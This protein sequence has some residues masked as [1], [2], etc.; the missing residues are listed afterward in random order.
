MRSRIAAPRPAAAKRAKKIRG[1]N[2]KVQRNFSMGKKAFDLNQSAAKSQPMS[3]AG[4]NAKGL[5]RKTKWEL[6]SPFLRQYGNSSMAYSTLQEGLEYFVDERDGYAAFSTITHPFLSRSGRQMVLGNPICAEEHY[7]R[8]LDSLLSVHKNPVFL[9]VSDSFQKVL[10][11]RGYYATRMGVETELPI[12][13]YSLSGRRKQNIRTSR[14]QALKQGITV[15]EF[16][17]GNTSDTLE[18][19]SKEWISGRILNSREIWYFARRLVT[20]KEEDV[21]GFLARNKQGGPLGFIIFDPMYFNNSIHGYAA[22]IARFKEGFK[23]GVNDTVILAA[24]EKF[25]EEGRSKLNLGLSPLRNVGDETRPRENRSSK[26]AFR[27]LYSHGNFVYNFRNLGFHKSRYAGDE[28]PVYFCSR[29]SIQI[30]DI[31]LAMKNAG[32]LMSGT[33]LFKKLLNNIIHPQ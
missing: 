27:F 18:D 31:Y 24:L 30:R 2:S 1:F 14:N 3:I 20:E 17:L 26:L 23:Q 22:N 21:R 28:K 32:L 5:D 29:D 25:K 33:E 8:F 10:L 7:G 9:Q 12:Q 4:R 16:D 13:T 11:E 19:I 6:L 15:E